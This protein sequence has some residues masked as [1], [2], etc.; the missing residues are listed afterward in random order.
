MAEFKV[1]CSLLVCGFDGRKIPHIFSV[2]SPGIAASHD[3]PGFHAVG[4][5]RDVAIGELYHFETQAKEALD[6][7]LYELFDAKAQAELIQGVGYEWDCSV[8]TAD[9]EPV[10]MTAA[11]RKAVE[12]IFEEVTASPY[13]PRWASKFKKIPEWKKTLKEFSDSVLASP[14]KHAVKTA[15][16][17]HPKSV[18]QKLKSK[19]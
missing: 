19:Q 2:V 8:I 11:A 9:K 12:G 1:S 13:H 14:K 5:G 16:K 6:I 10:E 18:P 15:V 7:A 17:P 3:I 4:V